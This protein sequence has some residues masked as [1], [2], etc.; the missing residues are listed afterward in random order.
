MR[1]NSFWP[2]IH[3]QEWDKIASSNV[4][5]LDR[6]FKINLHLITTRSK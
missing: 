5:Q 3:L 1:K 2:K 6:P 4:T